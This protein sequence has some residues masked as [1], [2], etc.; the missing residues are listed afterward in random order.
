MTAKALTLVS[1]L[2][3]AACDGGIFGTGGPDTIMTDPTDGPDL[4]IDNSAESNQETAAN[5][6]GTA[7]D[8]G[9]TDTGTN[10]GSASQNTPE[11]TTSGT[12][13]GTSATAGAGASAPTGDT[14]VDSPTTEGITDAGATD[15]GATD[16]GAT[17]TGITDQDDT[18]G[19]SSNFDSSVSVGENGRF[20]NETA[21][22]NG[23]NARL[24]VINNSALT[25]NVV[26]PSTDPEAVLFA[27]AGIA[28]NMS[29]ESASLN[30]NTKSLNIVDN[31]NPS[32]VLISYSEFNAE[33]ETLTT[34]LIR[35]DE[36][37]INAVALV[38]ETQTTDP[39][40]AKVRI[41]QGGTLGDRSLESQLLLQ[42]AG[43]NPGGMDKSFGPL[44]FDRP[45]SDYMELSAGDYELVDLAN[46]FAPIPVT[47]SG[48]TVYT[49]LLTGNGMNEVRI[50]VDSNGL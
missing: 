8:T 27:S 11:S 28:P 2:L 9:A 41:V 6:M 4:S 5:T 29:S 22:H 33:P 50:I 24:V 10:T 21:A 40:L 18:D 13:A 49:L 30:A 17:D 7:G 47:L 16:T 38:T 15:T 44:S 34:L 23:P 25:L 45:Q 48:N 46:R 37:G 19:G 20:I 42:S 12:D 1:V 39:G 36:T 43:D 26:S 35:E 31:N 3:L 14:G 32:Q